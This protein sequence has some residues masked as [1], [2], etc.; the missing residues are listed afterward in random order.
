MDLS[1]A[2]DVTSRRDAAGAPVP[3]DIEFVTLDRTRNRPSRHVR[4]QQVVRG[5]A[6]HNLIRAGQIAVKPADGSGHTVPVHVRLIMRINGER[7][8]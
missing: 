1:Q 8:I 5:G 3:F 7:V 2:L 4:M 6:S